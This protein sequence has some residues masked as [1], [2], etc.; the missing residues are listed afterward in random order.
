MCL[1]QHSNKIHRQQAPVAQSPPE[2]FATKAATVT[3]SE[4]CNQYGRICETHDI[5]KV[6]IPDKTRE[7]VQRKR[8]EVQRRRRGYPRTQVT[9]V[10]P[11]VGVR[12]KK[13]QRGRPEG[14]GFDHI[15]LMGALETGKLLPP[16]PDQVV[17]TTTASSQLQQEKTK[18]SFLPNVPLSRHIPNNLSERV[19]FTGLFV[20][21]V[22]LASL[23]LL[24]MYK[25]LWLDQMRCPEGFVFKSQHCT[26]EARLMHSGQ[27]GAISALGQQGSLYSALARVSQSKR[28]IPELLP[29]SW[30]PIVNA[31]KEAQLANEEAEHAHQ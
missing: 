16:P 14:D 17:V 27:Q 11:G 12:E 2:A 9:M 7:R 26:P 31:L 1:L 19:K 21:M 24:V 25:S 30:L 20:A 3:H 28:P 13:L 23:L 6:T 5:T 29:S 15:P 22:M 8:A 18:M 10:K 4:R